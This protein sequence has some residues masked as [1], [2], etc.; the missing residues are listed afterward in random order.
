MADLTADSFFNSRLSV[1]QSRD[2]YRFSIDAAL[3]AAH[4][5]PRPDDIVVDAGTGCGIVALIMAFRHPG[6]RVF[7]VEI[8]K[9][10]AEIAALNV[11]ENSM[12]DRIQIIHQ[13]VRTLKP[14]A[15][16]DP[17]DL[18]VI[19]PP[20]RKA[21]SGRVNPHPEKAQARH[22]YSLSLSEVMATARRLL[23]NGGRLL[24]IYPA[25]RAAEVLVEMDKAG[26]APKFLR[27]VHSKPGTEAR[28][29]LTGGTKGARPG[30]LRIDTPLVIYR[31]DGAYADE[32]QAMFE[33]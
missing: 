13:D 15:V 21:Q 29:V 22:E 20:F 8:Q 19:N 3:L 23:R 18:M 14:D 7:G 5:A 12:E 2:G 33:G 16:S 24:T 25:D 30:G 9:S 10:L 1:F 17:I 11:R 6:I 27:T 4:A 31:A 28:L 26:V 32:V